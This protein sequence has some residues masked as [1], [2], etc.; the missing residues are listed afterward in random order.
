MYICCFCFFAC[1]QTPKI[2]KQPSPQKE[3]QSKKEK[4]SFLDSLFT[5]NA[6]YKATGFDFPVGK[7]NAKNYYNAQSFTENNHLGDDWNGISGGNTDLGDPIFAIGNG[8]VQF[9]EDIGGGWG[10]VI[11]IIHQYK[12]NYYESLYAHC[13]TISVKK[14]NFVSKGNQIGTIGNANGMYYAHLHLEIRD[15]I[16]MDI[17]SGYSQSTNGYIDP[18]LFIKSNR[19]ESWQK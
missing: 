3:I 13:D 8:Y 19:N 14:G 12:G 15:Q 10:K 4:F 9:A 6:T 17:G 18:T 11:R 7:P 1:Q 2:Q 5:K 16:F